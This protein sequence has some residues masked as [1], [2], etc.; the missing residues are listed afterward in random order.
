LTMQPGSSDPAGDKRSGSMNSRE[1]IMAAL[2]G[3]PVDRVPYVPHIGGYSMASLPD[4]YQQMTRWR[5]LGEIGADLFIRARR[6]FA[7]WPP[8][9]FAPPS[10]MVSPAWLPANQQMPPLKGATDQRLKVSRARKGHETLVTLDTP[11]GQLRSLWKQTSESPLVPFPVEPLLKTAEDLKVYQ[12]AL[13]RTVV[14]PWYEDLI[15]TQAALRGAGVVEAV[16]NC[17]PIQDL[18]MWHMGLDSTVFMMHDQPAEIQSLMEMM[19][20]VRK[21]EYQ[22]LAESPADVVVTYENTSTTLLSPAY[23]ARYE[24]PALAEYSDILHRGGKLHLVHMCGKIQGV[25]DLISQAPLNGITDVAPPPTGNC[26]FRV[27]REKLDSAGK[28]LAGG[29]DAT[30]FVH[31]A[32]DQMQAYVLHRLRE[33][34]PGT[35]FLLGS[36]DAVPFGTPLENLQAAAMAVRAH[37]TYPI[38][39]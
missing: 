6:G 31:C 2:R 18:I 7:S 5:F 4:R 16:G 34:A 22:V 17:T 12:Y 35:G 32:P 14:E 37:G 29:I 38:Q 13:E 3:Q 39:T 11:V 27:A 28:S 1:R 9:C 36:G 23:M 10:T 8:D 33:V 21:R 24:F 20:E 25:L 30:A 19:Q 15:A 26:D